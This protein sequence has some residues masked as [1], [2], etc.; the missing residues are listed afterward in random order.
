MRKTNRSVMRA[1]KAIRKV[2]ARIAKGSGA[3]KQ[4][5]DGTRRCDRSLGCS[6]EF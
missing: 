2:M 6:I 3:L 5:G 1:N 4:C